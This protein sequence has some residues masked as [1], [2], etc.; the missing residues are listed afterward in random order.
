MEDIGKRIRYYRNINNLGQKEL[1]EKLHVAVSTISNWETG[2]NNVSPDFYS[3]LAEAFHI[4]VFE[5]IEGDKI[6]ENNQPARLAGLSSKPYLN[7]NYKTDFIF[8]GIIFIVVV[9][10]FLSSI[11]NHLYQDIVLSLWLVLFIITCIRL[12]NAYKKN[13]STKYFEDGQT[14][15]YKHQENEM[16]IRSNKRLYLFLATLVFVS[17]NFLIIISFAN[18]LSVTQDAFNYMFFPIL[19]IIINVLIIYSLLID[20]KRSHKCKEVPYESINLSFF[21]A[22]NKLLIFFYLVFYLY[23]YLSISVLSLDMY[24]GLSMVVFHIDMALTLLA[25]IIMY[26]I[27]KEFYSKYQIQVK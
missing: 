7:Y 23:H 19:L 18:I 21:L 2:R 9:S 14:L 11:F 27:N 22:R 5:L 3:G 10:T 4:S 13:I 8:L 12:M 24:K 6:I 17:G 1:A 16:D 20:S 25:V 26:E 15:Y